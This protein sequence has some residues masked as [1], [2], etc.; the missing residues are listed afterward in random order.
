MKIYFL[1]FFLIIQSIVYSQVLP[2]GDR[3]MAWQIDVAANNNYDSAF[4]YTLNACMESTHLAIEWSSLDSNNGQFN[5][6]F[7][8][9][10][11]T[12]AN[13]YYPANA[14]AVELQLATINTVSKSVPKDLLNLNFD[15]PL[16]ISRFK[17]SL[18]T[19]FS[20]IP[21][22][23]LS[24]LNIGNE[25]DIYFGSDTLQ[26]LQYKTFLDAVIPYA[27]GI[28]FNLHQKDLK[29]G[30]TLT[31]NS[32]THPYWSIW[33]KKIN[34]NC[35]IISVT[36]YPLNSDFTMKNPSV[37]FSDFSNL[38]SNYPD[39]FKP[40]YF[41]ECGYSSS[42]VCNSS[43][44]LQAQFYSNV[45]SAWDIHYSNI[46]Y[47]SMFKL[48]D[49]SISDANKY[50]AIYGFPNDTI[51]K[52]YLRTLGVRNYPGNGSN[53]LAFDRIQCELFLRNWCGSSSCK[54]VSVNNFIQEKK[55][56]RIYPNPVKDIL[57]LNVEMTAEVIIYD[58]NF[59]PLIK[60]NLNS[61]NNQIN[62]SN[63]SSGVYFLIVKD[64]ISTTVLKF[65]KSN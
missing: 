27:K 16:V 53:K 7:T 63:L 12:A 1:I 36:Y 48:T 65:V 35:D 4:T 8:N 33:C 23:E 21:N 3:T 45:F 61:I 64:K 49:W 58:I 18:D 9:N 2:K 37:V 20:R 25:H 30:S 19:L 29:I 56:Y 22:L 13:S 51:F 32:L 10:Y 6:A 62:T 17:Q 50:A 38:V 57:H 40:I 26:Y 59:R 14:I 60:N 46:K 43:E 24:T 52:E 34:E 55:E 5:T 39:T 15:H 31:L 41:A 54:P 44:A 11:L 28:Y 42:S 47:I